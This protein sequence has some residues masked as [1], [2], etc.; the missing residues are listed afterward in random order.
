MR[1]IRQLDMTLAAT[2]MMAILS[3]V[4]VFHLLVLSGVI[5]Y[6]I[7]WGGRLENATQM[8]V[9][10]TIAITINL[11]I[12][13]V[14]SIKG[15]YIR[16]FLPSKVVTSLLWD[17]VILFALNTVGNLFAESKVEMALFTPLTFISTVLLLR[18][19]IEC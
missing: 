13:V 16:P 18:M 17:L 9:F 6:H 1:W 4:V 8:Y 12:I 11:A 19:A 5:P 10:E 14:V 2:M 15:G 7:V 3:C